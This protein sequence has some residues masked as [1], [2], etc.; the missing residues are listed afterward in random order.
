[1]ENRQSSS[2][3][4]ASLDY[5]TNL[6][7]KI[8]VLSGQFDL[9][10]DVRASFAEAGLADAVQRHD[11]DALFA[12][13]A[14]AI[15]FQG[16]S[17]SVAAGYIE[18]HGI[19]EAIDVRLGL[20]S[21]RLCP[22]LQSYWHFSECGYR[23]G[24]NSCNE[25]RHLRQ[26]PLPRHDLRNGSLNQAAYGMYLFMR[27]I[28]DGDFVFWID[29][30]LSQANQG[31]G[32]RRL[33]RLRDAVVLPLRNVH[34]LS[35]KVLNMSL[36]NLLL[37]GDPSR[38]LWVEAGAG[39]IAVDSLVHN[40]MWRSGILRKLEAQHVYGPACYRP[41]GCAA[42]I[43]QVAL[44]IDARVFNRQFPHVFP[45]FIQ[46]AIWSFCAELGFNQCN[47][48]RIDDSSRCD[49][50]ECALFGTCGRVTLNQA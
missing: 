49:Q 35:D 29:S 7:R 14:E 39:M 47:G 33:R 24:S 32:L 23:K 8:C 17:D 12:W 46:K 38:T 40:W 36:G 21:P 42:I 43:E 45:R 22:K 31:V 1:M 48:R 9:I 16:I 13:L 3:P 27:D 2:L 37:G 26:C 28:A 25:P 18:Q 50:S 44:R 5:A 19:V 30:R 34:G 15:S 4:K 20:K 6:I 10:E 11:S 41:D